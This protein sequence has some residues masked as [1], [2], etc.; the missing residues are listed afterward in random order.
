MNKIA[1]AP[2]SL[3]P[4]TP[5]DAIRVSSR[6][7]EELA[8]GFGDA[9]TLRDALAELVIRLPKVFPDFGF[10]DEPPTLIITVARHLTGEEQAQLELAW[11][12]THRN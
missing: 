3:V 12:S 11:I 8:E 7:A 2:V 10:H 9:R 4:T 1:G 5:T 6:T